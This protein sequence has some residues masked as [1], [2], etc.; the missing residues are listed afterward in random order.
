MKSKS[1]KRV[2]ALFLAVIMIAGSCFAVSATENEEEQV[3]EEMPVS[4][5]QEEKT[6][7]DYM[8]QTPDLEYAKENITIAC[9]E[10]KLEEIG[11]KISYSFTV[12]EDGLYRINLTYMPLDGTDLN[13]AIGV[14]LDGEYPFSG[15]ENTE[16]LR[17]YKNESEEWSTDEQG[18]EFSPEQ[19]EVQDWYSLDLFDKDGVEPET[20]L[21]ALAK[22][23][24]TI[25]IEIL[26]ESI[27]IS[28]ITFAAPEDVAEYKDIENDTDAENYDGEDI[29][30][31][32]EDAALK[33]SSSLTAKS[34]NISANVNPQTPYKNVINYIGGENWSK[35]GETITWTFDIEE[36][37]LYSMHFHYKQ[38]GV[39]NGKVFRWMQI[40][41]EL[42]FA[43]AKEI[44]F[45]YSTSWEWKTLGDDEAYE[46]YLK[47][48]THTLTMGVTISEMSEYYKELKN[49]VDVLGDQYLKIAMITGDTPD[50]ARDYE[51]FKQIPE[52]ESNFN[53]CLEKMAVLSEKMEDMSDTSSTQYVSAIKSMARVLNQMLER[54]YLAHT[55]K[56]DLYNQ[57]CS[58]S[59]LLY[60]MKQMPLSIDEIRFTSPDGSEAVEN[61]G[62]FWETLKFWTVSFFQSFKNDDNGTSEESEQTELK[63][64]VNWGRDQ[65]QVLN[66]MIQ[67]SFTA[68]TGIKVN[69][70]T[71][72]ATVIQGVLTDNAPD[73]AL[74]VNRSNPVNYAIR[75]AA[76]DLSQFEDFEEVIERFQ[77]GATVP[78][79][80]NGG[81]YALPDT[82]N[83]YIMYYRQDI[84]DQIGLEVPETWDEFIEATAVLQR[85][86]MNVYLPYTR[87]INASIVNT[88]V[89]G[90]NLYSTLLNQHQVNIY[91]EEGTRNNLDSTEAIEV[92]NWWTDMYTKYKLAAE[93]EFYNRFR[94][95]V[96]PLGVAPY[97]LYTQISQTSPE[98]E[99]KWGISLIPGV[100]QEDG[101][102]N[103]S[104][105]G[106]G[107][108][109]I[110]LNTSEHKDEAWEFLKWWTREDTQLRYSRNV[111]SL[112]GAVG[113][114]A[115]SNV[116]AFSNYSWKTE[117]RDLLLEQWEQVEE[118]REV[119]G[120]YYLARAV[121]QAFW[122]T[123][124]GEKASE[125]IIRWSAVANDEIERKIKEYSE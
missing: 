75:G 14:K 50:P 65:T 125:S 18:N 107:T 84:L 62:S 44:P 35:S 37:G 5:L 54:K 8:A 4:L 87:L 78:Y 13:P 79:E 49:I 114:V 28:Q 71:T 106:S 1:K 10:A 68:E 22:G 110:I 53:D 94:V 63:I 32:G 70:Q 82:Q 111:E 96:T 103:R 12:S 27:V 123:V 41:G 109:C 98:I 113:R 48:G 59:A 55:Y 40:D 90:L 93:Q 20:Y 52:M 83:F 21:V 57:Y 46:I 100:E 29:V 60:D 119:P 45:Q 69:V 80:Y 56:T 97:S 23:E 2:I 105:S 17:W 11:Q 19:V 102:V 51:L 64:W 43:E 24:H 58:L 38:S 73:L 6:Y 117:D 99:G 66:A 81:T 26:Q 3:I 86:N 91:N 16:L 76:Y 104:S 124:N 31:Q 30:L 88:G 116:E 15:L 74:H 120:S 121:D 42:P 67:E 47:E 25:E 85:N 36:S 95:G 118:I 89:G 34:D 122:A 72:D 101:T 7:D 33:S 39:V 61:N 115:T 77:D 112:L 108:G 9:E 92:F